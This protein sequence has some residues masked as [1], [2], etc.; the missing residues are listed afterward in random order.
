MLAMHWLRHIRRKGFMRFVL[1]TSVG[2]AP[3]RGWGPSVFFPL[4]LM[5]ANLNEAAQV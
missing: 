2:N 4:L 3:Y 5:P 1:H